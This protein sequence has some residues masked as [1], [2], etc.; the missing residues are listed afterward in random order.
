LS[1]NFILNSFHIY[2]SKLVRFRKNYNFFY[3]KLVISYIININR[4]FLKDEYETTLLNN[5]VD[6]DEYNFL[7]S[8]NYKLNKLC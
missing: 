2:C 1:F 7:L 6:L 3:N 4:L 5:F 8:E